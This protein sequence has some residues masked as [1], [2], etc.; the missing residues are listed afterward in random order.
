MKLSFASDYIENLIDNNLLEFSNYK[1]IQ[2]S[3]KLGYKLILYSGRGP[4][5][6]THIGHLPI[7]RILKDLQRLNNCHILYQVSDD[8]KFYNR[9]IDFKDL[10]IYSKELLQD[11]NK[12]GYIEQ[13]TH[14]F[15]SSENFGKLYNISKPLFRKFTIKYFKSLLGITDSDNIGSLIYSPIQAGVCLIPKLS[16]DKYCIIIVTSK[17]QIPHF[18]S[19]IKYIK[20]NNLKIVISFI[21]IKELGNILSNGKMSS[22]Y[23]KYALF[24]KDSEFEIKRKIKKSFSGAR[25]SLLEFKKLGLDKNKDFCYNL[26]NFLDLN[27]DLNSEYE[28][29][30]VKSI[31]FKNHTY[32]QLI[33]YM[34]NMK[35]ITN[36]KFKKINQIQLN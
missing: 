30:L 17:D 29:G 1:E 21:L 18:R 11:L 35:I 34:K 4:S 7:L 16:L 10:E 8:Q 25:N 13:K 32:S 14:I 28:K 3:I 36:I 27:S 26:I 31:D 12:L 22:K 20:H 2:N 33:K 9:M 23:P 24:L 15:K 6:F 19:I 5:N